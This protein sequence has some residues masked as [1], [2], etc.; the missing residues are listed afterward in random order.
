MRT[1]KFTSGFVVLAA[2]AMLAAG[3]GSDA[4]TTEEKVKDSV[5]SVVKE[6]K[7]QIAA[8]GDP[9]DLISKSDVESEFGGTVADGKKDG[10]NC[11]YGITGTTKFGT[12]G[13]IA[14]LTVSAR[15]EL[16][17]S[18]STF[19]TTQKAIGGTALSG[20][21]DAAYFSDLGGAIVSFFASGK[22]VSIQTVSVGSADIDKADL[23][24]PTVALA[25][26]A[27]G[28]L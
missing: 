14:S 9:C 25:K 11:E 4:K 12:V 7:E 16:I 17:S 21:G 5:S 22:A 27:V 23:K 24:D 3:C 20:V 18:Q 10:D 13:D 6:G 8:K 19:E 2:V 15:Y 1:T 28:N 26:T